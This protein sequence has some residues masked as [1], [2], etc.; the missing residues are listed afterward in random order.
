VVINATGM[1]K[2]RP[3]SP[4]TDEAR[5]P[6]DG[7]AWELNYRGALDFLHQAEAQRDTRG[8]TVEDGWLYFLHGWTR[9]IAEV[10]HLDLD[11]ETF[12][13]LAEVAAEVR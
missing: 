3:G 11:R 6:V 1:G 7:V 4:V 13:R 9:V 10:L 8:G 5:F 2:D 12:E